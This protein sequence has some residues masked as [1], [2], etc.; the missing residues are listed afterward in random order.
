MPESMNACNGG[1]INNLIHENH[2]NRPSKAVIFC[3]TVL[4]I[5]AYVPS[6]LLSSI[7]S[8][9]L[10]VCA[11]T[12]KLISSRCFFDDEHKCSIIKKPGKALLGAL[13]CAVGAPVL[14]LI[15]AGSGLVYGL[16]SAVATLPTA[17]S[18]CWNNKIFDVD[19][20]GG[21][22]DNIKNFGSDVNMMKGYIDKYDLDAFAS[23]LKLGLVS[24]SSSEVSILYNYFVDKILDENIHGDLS[25]DDKREVL[26]K[27]MRHVGK[28]YMESQDVE[29]DYLKYIEAVKLNVLLILKNKKPDESKLTERALLYLNEKN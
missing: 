3:R 24:L 25:C 6:M 29:N 26:T 12:V 28:I 15:G 23:V 1:V 19:F 18:A 2:E 9:V 21:L 5:I 22:L 4:V 11:G 16:V 14:L 13:F 7:G 10:N 17:F 20:S 27:F 8:G